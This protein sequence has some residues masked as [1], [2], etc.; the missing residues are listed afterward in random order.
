MV[1]GTGDWHRVDSPAG[2]EAY[3][4]PNVSTDMP[5]IEEAAQ[6]TPGEVESEGWDTIVDSLSAPEASGVERV[7]IDFDNGVVD[8]KDSSGRSTYVLAAVGDRG[9]FSVIDDSGNVSTSELSSMPLRHHV[10]ITEAV[11]DSV[12]FETDANEMGIGFSDSYADQYREIMSSGE[13]EALGGDVVFDFDGVEGVSDYKNNDKAEKFIDQLDDIAEFYRDFEE[14]YSMTDETVDPDIPVR[15]EKYATE[16]GYKFRARGT[17][18]DSNIVIS[19]DGGSDV[20]ELDVVA[21]S[22][23]NGLANAY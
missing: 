7:G 13:Y 23:H 20:I 17:N 19:K 1:F 22:N 4:N 16:K 2:G 8:V 12:G 10:A 14:D 5:S 18:R 21:F 15:P 9:E 3:V 11:F 6:L